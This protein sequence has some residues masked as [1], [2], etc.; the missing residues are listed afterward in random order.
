MNLKP[1]NDSIIFQFLQDVVGRQFNQT[2][3]TGIQ[4]V[5][6]KDKQVKEA[7]WGKVVAIGKDVSEDDVKIG[8][9]IYIAPL[10]WTNS[11]KYQGQYYWRTNLKSVL[12]TS[13]EDPIQ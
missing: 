13:S 3:K 6:A 2:T 11:L 12:S 1:L 8:D 4:I 9:F 10:M 5:E 7:R